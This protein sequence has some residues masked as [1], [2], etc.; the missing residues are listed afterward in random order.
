[1]QF[2]LDFMLKNV[3]QPLAF[4]VKFFLT[5]Y[6]ASIKFNVILGSL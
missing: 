4:L 2:T 5:S 1:M 6:N 3:L